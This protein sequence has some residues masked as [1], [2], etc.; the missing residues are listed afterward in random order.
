[1]EFYK[2]IDGQGARE[3]L[4]RPNNFKPIV[5]DD[6]FLHLM[7]GRDDSASFW[8]RMRRVEASRLSHDL[9]AAL[10]RESRDD[11]EA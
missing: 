4:T 1:M 10:R 3:P 5:G 7:L 2:I 11:H 9:R 8:L 6:G